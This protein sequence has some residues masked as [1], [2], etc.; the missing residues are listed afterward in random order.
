[1]DFEKERIFCVQYKIK[2]RFYIIVYRWINIS[3]NIFVY[4]ILNKKFNINIYKR[5]ILTLKNQHYM[6][7]MSKNVKECD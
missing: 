2:W 4:C 7:Y 5:L 1:M 6:Y 3:F